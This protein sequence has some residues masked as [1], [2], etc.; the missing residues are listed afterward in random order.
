MSHK[1]KKP[2][3]NPLPSELQT[4]PPSRDSRNPLSYDEWITKNARAKAIIMAT[5]VPGS[6]A[7]KIAEP[8]EYASDIWKALEVKYGPKD[9]ANNMCQLGTPRIK[10]R[11]AVE[12]ARRLDCNDQAPNF[13]PAQQTLNAV[14]SS[15]RVG[16]SA[17]KVGSQAHLDMN[18]S[19]AGS[20]IDQER[21]DRRL[22]WALL[23]GGKDKLD[24]VTIQTGQQ[25]CG[26]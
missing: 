24:A 14:A 22:L 16:D 11:D 5:L 19:P 10:S 2:Y 21:R 6:E 7:W 20:E 17:S 13:S 8:L 23:N 25:L 15:S 12:A 18:T 1:I 26:L 3:F 4:S 9:A